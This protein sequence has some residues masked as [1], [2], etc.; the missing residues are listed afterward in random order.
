MEQIP[1]TLKMIFHLPSTPH[2][3]A[4]GRI[5]DSIAGTSSNVHGFQYMNIFAWHLC[6]PYQETG[7][8]QGTKAASDQIRS[9]SFYSHWFLWSGKC[10]IV[11]LRIINTLAV[12]FLTAPLGIPIVRFRNLRLSHLI[13]RLHLSLSCLRKKDGS[14]SYRQCRCHPHFPC[15]LS[16]TNKSFLFAVIF[17]RKKGF[18]Q[19]LTIYRYYFLHLIP[20]MSLQ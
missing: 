14:C 3:I 13:H 19:D 17:R 16:H 15:I 12:L 11:S 9:F 5:M 2:H 10:L 20:D 1:Q 7:R 6:I 18:I 8:R 4:S